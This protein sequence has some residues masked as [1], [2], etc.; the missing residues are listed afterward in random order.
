MTIR[1]AYRRA[2]I[3]AGI[4]AASAAFIGVAANR[5]GLNSAETYLS[6]VSGLILGI[7]IFLTWEES[8]VREPLT[9]LYDLNEALHR[10]EKMQRGRDRVFAVTANEH[11][12]DFDEYVVQVLKSSSEPQV[13]RIIDPDHWLIQGYLDHFEATWKYLHGEGMSLAR[14]SLSFAPT[15]SVG[16]L[17]TD[18]ESGR[19]GSI[20]VYTGVPRQVF[21]TEGDQPGLIE[22][23]EARLQYV[24]KRNHVSFPNG[25][26]IPEKYDAT[27]VSNWLK[28]N[29]I[30]GRQ[31]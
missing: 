22:A 8:D 19:M 27:W 24:K 21:Y 23:V 17:L 9:V 28:K 16:V 4:S 5:L 25:D 31:S 26:V 13:E 10:A 29:G 3:G 1:R 7:L 20:W 12:R 14:Y 18:G 11:T 6:A 30:N 15:G 2:F